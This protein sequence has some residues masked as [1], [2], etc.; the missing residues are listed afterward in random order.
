MLLISGYNRKVFKEEFFD[1]FM[2]KNEVK[3]RMREFVQDKLKGQNI[4]VSFQCANLDDKSGLFLFGERNEGALVLIYDSISGQEFG[5]LMSM[6]YRLKDKAEFVF[7]KDGK[8]F[9][10]S[11]SK[12]NQFKGMLGLSLKKYSSKDLAESIMLSPAETLLLERKS[13]V[14]NYYQPSSARLEEEV[15]SYE[16]EPFNFDYSHIDSLL[17]HRPDNRPSSRL[18]KPKKV[19]STNFFNPMLSR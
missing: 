7:L 2:V 14:L 6:A 19:D 5:S 18:F 3:A 11:G 13:N 8:T 16:F 1:V 4:P 12:N 10:R 17:Q 9:F 15:V